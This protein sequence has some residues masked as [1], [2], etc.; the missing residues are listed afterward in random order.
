MNPAFFSISIFPPEPFRGGRSHKKGRPMSDG[1]SYFGE[2]RSYRM[3][4]STIDLATFMKP[5]MLAP[6]M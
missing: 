2:S 6:F 5:A 4:C 1:L 3:P